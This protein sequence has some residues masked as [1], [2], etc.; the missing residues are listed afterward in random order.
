MFEY[1]TLLLSASS[2]AVIGLSINNT[3][4][5]VSAM[6]ISPLMGPLLDITNGILQKN[7]QLIKTGIVTESL[8]VLISLSTG[9][10]GGLIMSSFYI[11][12][13]P[14]N[15]MVERTLLST[16]ILS[17]FI[18][19]FSSFAV[20]I[21]IINDDIGTTIGTA[22]STSILPPAINS[23]MLLA[24][25]T[26]KNDSEY[27][28]GSII[29]LGITLINITII[30]SISTLTVFLYELKQSNKIN[31]FQKENSSERTN[32]TCKSNET[33]LNENFEI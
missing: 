5:I 21:K 25:C 24:Y 15:E 27:I 32:R 7:N 11:N 30:V 8:G 22:I 17:T 20:G 10:V 9:Y 6:L 1:I 12:K 2:I 33:I 29:S 4:I 26:I 23:G 13:W 31:K 18:A 3:I 16:M 14:N 19:I 28:I